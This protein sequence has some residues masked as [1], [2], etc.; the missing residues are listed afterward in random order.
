MRPKREPA[1]D[2][3][4]TTA[5]PADAEA[6]RS[7]PGAAAKSP[8]TL[9]KISRPTVAKLSRST[10]RPNLTQAIRV[11]PDDV[12]GKPQYTTHALRSQDRVNVHDEIEV[13]YR[14]LDPH[15]PDRLP[16]EYT[17]RLADISLDGAQ[18]VGP[19][20]PRLGEK[21]LLAG[22]ALVRAEM[23][24]P[25]VER[26]LVVESLV[27]WVRQATPSGYCMGLK[28]RNVTADQRKLIR[29]FLIGLQSPTRMKF[30]RGRRQD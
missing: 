13:R 7:L 11:G 9:A 20:A 30:R 3:P 24:L 8:G 16:G 2:G 6:G 4:D 5:P 22:A 27:A 1:T 14:F 10:P 19:L 21:E 29:G 12:P 15:R 28:F 23:S 18:L 25:F 26:P 17:G